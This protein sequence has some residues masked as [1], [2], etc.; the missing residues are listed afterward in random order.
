MYARKQQYTQSYQVLSS[1][2]GDRPNWSVTFSYYMDQSIVKIFNFWLPMFQNDFDLNV[3][4]LRY[5]MSN[6]LNKHF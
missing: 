6:L 2:F 1:I 3:K 4:Y 5:S